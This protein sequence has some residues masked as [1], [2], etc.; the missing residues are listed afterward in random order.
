MDGWGSVGDLSAQ[1]STFLMKNIQAR[2]NSDTIIVAKN[3]SCNM[4][5]TQQDIHILL[6]CITMAFYIVTTTAKYFYTTFSCTGFSAPSDITCSYTL[7]YPQTVNEKQNKESFLFFFCSIKM[8]LL[9][10][11]RK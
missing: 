1:T 2:K 7:C 6:D 8:L 5:L 4:L 11:T 10:M 3:T 9:A